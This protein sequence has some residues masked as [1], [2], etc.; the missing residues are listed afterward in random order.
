[1]P[2]VRGL[3]YQCMINASK[4]IT[5]T[6]IC[7]SLRTSSSSRL[8]ILGKTTILYQ[9]KLNEQV[10][11]I[12]TFGFN[13]QKVSSCKGLTF[14]VW[15]VGGQG[16]LR[17]LWKHYYQNTEGKSWQLPGDLKL[18]YRYTLNHGV[19]YILYDKKYFDSASQ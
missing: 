9:L 8:P 5:K 13:V 16:K 4:M 6:I 18:N 19:D 15:D 12:P 2:H 11:T 10:T 17:D 1:M 3:V 7:F 14:T